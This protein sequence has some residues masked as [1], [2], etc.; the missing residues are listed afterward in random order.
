MAGTISNKSISIL[1]SVAGGGTLA[2]ESGQQIFSELDAIAKAISAGEGGKRLEVTVHANTAAFQK[3]INEA[4]RAASKNMMQSAQTAMSGAG[5][6]TG[7]APTSVK[8]VKIKSA[9]QIAGLVKFAQMR[10][11]VTDGEIQQFKVQQAESNKIT[12]EAINREKV[13]QAE[14]NTTGQ[15]IQHNYRISAE[16][17]KLQIEKSRLDKAHEDAE[18]ASFRKTTAM[19]KANEA[20]NKETISEIK[21]TE[22]ADK[23]S[24]REVKTRNA[25]LDKA[26]SIQQKY[27][28]VLNQTLAPDGRPLAA[29][30]AEINDQY[31]QGQLSAVG[32]AAKLG[33]IERTVKPLVQETTSLGSKMKDLFKRHF[34]IA[35]VMMVIQLVRRVLSQIYQNVKEIDLAMTELKKVTDETGKS[36]NDFLSRAGNTAQQLGTT[37]SNFVN[38]TAD[39]AR[40][41]YSLRESEELAK[42]AV[43]YK[44]VGD[45]IESIGDASESVISSMRAF[46]ISADDAMSIIDKFNAVGNTQ[47]IS[48]AG[49][50]EALQRSASALATAGNT[51]DQAVALAAA[52]NSV[53]QNPQQVGG[54]TRPMPW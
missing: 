53:V 12:T 11:N 45:G 28:E 27:G 54:H 38:A 13:L 49:I 10:K 24:L 39:F 14:L 29:H 16:A 8:D 35:A 47:P 37:I 40:L 52:A 20:A 2:G 15:R 22:T 34:E 42:V 50:G 1:F 36:Y 17:L 32:Y 3:E 44:N 5:A 7:G 25:L 43:V 4:V 33:D 51:I 41:G 48:S 19:H 26:A 31:E 21:K 30:L 46:N 6:A 18:A 23:A 9:Q